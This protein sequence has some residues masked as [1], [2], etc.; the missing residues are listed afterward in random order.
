MSKQ[1]DILPI[2][3]LNWNSFDDTK[4]CIES[5]LDSNPKNI[6][7]YLLDNGSA[8][9]NINALKSN[10]ENHPLI[11]LKFFDEN[12]GFTKAHNSIL[13]E[14]LLQDYKYVF[15]LN[16]DTIIEKSCL[17]NLQNILKTEEIDMI[18]CK[19]INYFDRERMDNAGHRLMT[20]GEIIPKF[21]NIPENSLTTSFENLGPCAGAGIYSIKMLQDI[22]LFDEYF[23]TGY[24][25][26]E[27]GLRAIMAGYKS[28]FYPELI[29][30]HKMGNSI[31][32]VFNY[33]YSLK[34]Q[35][36]V[37]YSYLK[38]V[39]WQVLIIQLIPFILRFLIITLVDIISFRHRH[40]KVQTV[41]LF[42]IMVK[43]LRMTIRARKLAKR[44]NR[45]SW[46]ELL[47]KQ[48]STLMRD[49]HNFIKY[50]IRGEKSY[51]EKY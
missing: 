26:A 2:V 22:G 47:L 16:N 32:K 36:C 3:I 13:K 1:V 4:E 40:L 8:I 38:L 31:K 21:H 41:A 30:F 20:S 48:E 27:I 42:T 29:I 45:L 5:I 7:I 49:Y 51:F 19:M 35:T 6:I 25:D 9:D 33:E 37:F 11:K 28:V 43:E 23:N 18:S 17:N 14:L 44:F 10:Y 12:L 24:E 46:R 39:H 15:L 50:I 34:I